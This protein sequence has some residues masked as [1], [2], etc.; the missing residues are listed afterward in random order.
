MEG[1][2]RFAAILALSSLALTGCPGSVEPPP[3]RPDSGPARDGAPFEPIDTDGDGLCDETE[4]SWGTDPTLP[5]TDGDGLTDRAERDFGFSPL[6]PGSPERDELVFLTETEA[7]ATQL[8]IERL[9]RGE[10]QT[11][12]A[13]FESLPV[14]DPI[15]IE[16]FD[17]LESS[18]AVGAVPMENVF[19]VRPEAGQIVGVFGRTQLVYEVRFAF[20]T[21]IPRS[22]ARAYPFRYQIKR[23]DG[24]LVYL[25]R[26]LL[27]I[28][29]RG[30]RLDT[31]DWCVPEGRCI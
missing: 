24:V 7:A 5:D 2:R 26:F 15:D 12:T 3:P 31:A 6:E 8:G 11:F 10:G 14:V 27:V 21:N 1:P 4:L 18:Q 13:A 29:P 17:F 22:C 25:S 16:A 23:D 19:E 9:V 20:G 28:L 30:E